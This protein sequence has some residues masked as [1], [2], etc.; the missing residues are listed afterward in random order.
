MRRLFREHRVAAVDIEF[1][2]YFHP[3]A[4]MARIIGVRNIIFTESNSGLLRARAP[5]R[6]ALLRL[7]AA[8]ATAPVKRFVAIS[9]FVR[10]QLL[11]LGIE[12]TRIAVIHKGIE[13]ARYCPSREARRELADH[14][15]ISDDTIILGT[16]TILRAFKHPEV[17]LN[18][19]AVLERRGLPFRLFVGGDGELRGEM[20]ALAERLGIAHK[21]HWLGYVERAEVFVRGWD[22][23]L[24]ASEGEAFGFALIEAM[25]CGVPVVAAASGAIPEIVVPGV[26]GILVPV[27]DHAAMANAIESLARD[28]AVRRSLAQ[29]GAERVQ[30]MFSVERAVQKTLDVYDSAWDVGFR[31]TPSASRCA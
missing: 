30:A 7:R 19:C 17:I 12:K 9:D 3:I 18:A 28:K 24:L 25:S 31:S 16:V 13:Q 10:R 23:F 14:Y 29:S 27:L 15:G 21:V 1:F 26:T 5:W 2:C 8:I 6:L 20:A 11:Q 22:V 4:W